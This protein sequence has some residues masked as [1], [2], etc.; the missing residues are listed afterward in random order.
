M[1]I[2]TR[3]ILALQRATF[4]LLLTFGLAH[5]ALV[6]ES[7]ETLNLARKAIEEQD[8]PKANGY[9]LTALQLDANSIEALRLVYQTSTRVD[10]DRALATAEA[11]FQ[12]PESSV[13]EK[14]KILTYLQLRGDAGRFTK[15]YDKLND[16]QRKLP[17]VIFLKCR[18]LA[19]RGGLELARPVLEDYFKT[20]ANEPRFRLLYSSML[21]QSDQEA[22]RRRG[23]QW[24]VELVK[25]KGAEGRLAF[26]L[27]MDAPVGTLQPEV[28]PAD[29]DAIAKEWTEPRPQ[30]QLIASSIKIAQAKGDAARQDEVLSQAITAH[31]AKNLELLCTW[32][33]GWQ[34]F[35]RILEIVDEAKGRTSVALYDH[36]LRALAAVN[37][38]EAAEAWLKTPH[39]QSLEISVW[40]SRAKLA[41]QRKDPAA[42]LE[43]WEKAFALAA[44]E[45]TPDAMLGLYRTGLELDLQEAAVRAVLE[46][47]KK[48]SPSFPAAA[49][50]QPAFTYLY[51]RDRLDDLLALIWAALSHESSNLQLVNNF[52]YFSMILN[53]DGNDYVAQA[54]KVVNA[55][56]GE[57]GFRA[58]L[59]LAHLRMGQ[60]AEA[61]SV[62]RQG[63]IDWCKEAPA[64]RAVHALALE[65]NG[66]T[67]EAK[68]AWTA[69]A[70]LH[71]A[72]AER[73]TI[74]SL[75]AKTT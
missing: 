58:T 44:K 25:A 10:P 39:P 75:R 4:A 36:R 70:D 6:Q 27:L 41:S 38:P 24:I 11:L 40:I 30:E 69:I 54:A 53:R 42:T 31:A 64:A 7:V 74:E 51:D 19:T 71:L 20:G 2:R 37:G 45:P 59:A 57:P 3:Q 50:L 66:M 13:E 33:A 28:F 26:N 68:A 12:H 15:L 8:W 62:L 73:K 52:L 29:L 67:E 35:D 22:D 47:G 5:A 65:K 61:L 60:N 49:Q 21:I 32:L 34:R 43:C 48:P 55:V 56:P 63:N 18:F 23:Q 17:D 16:E 14:V 1:R 9:A 72:T 46:A